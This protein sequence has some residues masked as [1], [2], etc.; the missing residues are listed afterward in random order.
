M[1][2]DEAF[3]VNESSFTSKLLDYHNILL[4]Q[5]FRL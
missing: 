3:D 2:Y 1:D 4:S 5:L